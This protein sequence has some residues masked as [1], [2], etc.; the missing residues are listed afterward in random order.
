MNTTIKPGDLIEWTY[1]TTG[2]LVS[3]GE[4]LWS[5]PLERWVPIGSNLI[6][7]LISIDD[8]HLMWLNREG[9]F[10][11]RVDDTTAGGGNW[12]GLRVVPR[13]RG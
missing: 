1:E 2:H 12:R 9:L 4:M 11:A 13:A 3:T 6:H 5:A 7:L 10:H 8:D